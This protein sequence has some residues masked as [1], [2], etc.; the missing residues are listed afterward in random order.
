MKKTRHIFLGLGANVGDKKKNIQKAVTLLAEKIENITSAPLYETKPWGYTEQ[1]NFLNTVVYGTTSL[2]PTDLL[3]FLK[4]TEQNIGRVWRF[5]FGPREIDIDILFYDD[6]IL[7]ESALQIPHP[8]LQGRDFVLKPL[9]D[10]DPNFTHPVLKKTIKQLY[11]ELPEKD[12]V[13]LRSV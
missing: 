11:D 8:R 1:G 6:V 3:R 5:R 9:M 12:R 2:S 4:E 13:I 10:L 7:N